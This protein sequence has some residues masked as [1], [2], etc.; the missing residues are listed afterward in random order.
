MP[1]NIRNLYDTRR[2]IGYD[3][4][5]IRKIYKLLDFNNKSKKKFRHL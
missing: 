3:F 5:Y 4:L 2:F 1:K